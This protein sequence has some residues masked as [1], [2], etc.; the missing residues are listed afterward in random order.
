M[1]IFGQ[2]YIFRRRTEEILIV[3]MVTLL[4]WFMFQAHSRLVNM[5]SLLDGTQNA[6]HKSGLHVLILKFFIENQQQ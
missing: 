1:Y 4:T 6:L 2:T 5:S 3:V